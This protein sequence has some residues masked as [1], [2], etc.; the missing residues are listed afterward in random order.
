MP[1]IT[2]VAQTAELHA[3]AQAGQNRGSRAGVMGLLDLLHRRPLGTREMF[4]DAINN[5]G[6][7]HT[8]SRCQEGPPPATGDVAHVKNRHAQKENS[9]DGCRGQE[10][11]ENS[12][13]RIAGTLALALDQVG[14]DDR[15]N[16]TNTA[17]QQRINEPLVVTGNLPERQAQDQGRDDGDFVAFEDIGRHTGAVADVVAHQVGDHGCVAGV[18]FRHV[19][20][21]LAHQV[22]ADVGRLGV[23]T[24]AHT[25]E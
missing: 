13:H 25:H 11:A 10:A 6:Q 23:D 21:D 19:S 9:G 14:A 18:V 16:H 12:A 2:R 8:C 24:A 7:Q 3:H 4:G 5:D 17:D 22:G 1:A 20:L 15:R